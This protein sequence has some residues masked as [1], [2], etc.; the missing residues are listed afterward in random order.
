M[1]NPLKSDYKPF[2]I[3]DDK[4]SLNNDSN[5]ETKESFWKWICHELDELFVKYIP[6]P[7]LRDYPPRIMYPS[8]TVLIILIVLFWAALFGYLFNSEKNNTFL[9]PRDDSS[10][11]SGATCNDVLVPNTG[12]YLATREGKWEGASGFDYSVAAYSLTASSWMMDTAY[13]ANAM[14][15]LKEYLE[16]VGE[17][18]SQSDLGINL[19]YWF[20]FIGL[21][22]PKNFANRF[23]LCGDPSVA[24][25]RQNIF[26]TVSSI[27]GVCQLPGQVSSYDKANGVLRLTLPY[28]EYINS[29]TCMNAGDPKYLGYDQYINADN[30]QITI[31]VYSLAT[32]VAVNLNILLFNGLIEVIALRKPLTFSDGSTVMTSSYHNPKF[33][34]MTPIVCIIGVYCFLPLG[35]SNYAIPFFHHMGNDSYFPQRC[36]CS[37]MSDTNK[38]DAYH[39]CNRFLF[40]TGFYFFSSDNLLPLEQFIKIHPYTSHSASYY[41][42]FTSSAFGLSSPYYYYF[43]DTAT[44]DVLYDFCRTPAGNCTMVTFS[45]YDVSNPGW[46]ISDHYFQLL[47]GACQ[48]QVTSSDEAW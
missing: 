10:G 30:L 39:F 44:L 4:I 31:D 42:A 11:A 13:Y 26:G 12:K 18:T 3:K 43:Q 47:N 37:K 40:L 21:A 29:Q 33:P 36:D 5:E 17:T 20:S 8:G 46:S 48:D 6:F 14:K 7:D 22:D 38:Q 27:H 24:L 45:I 32:A 35:D 28:S 2:S 41:S 25:N 23:T 34:G 15:L 9:A 1:S 19:L 16:S